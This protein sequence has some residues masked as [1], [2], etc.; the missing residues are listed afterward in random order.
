MLSGEKNCV[1]SEINDALFD[2]SQDIGVN[3]KQANGTKRGW[4]L[5]NVCEADW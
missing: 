1:L 5:A 3:G 4:D 2:I